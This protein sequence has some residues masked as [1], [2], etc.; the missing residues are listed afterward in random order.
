MKPNEIVSAGGNVFTYM[1]AANQ[2]NEI[3]QM[4]EFILAITTS[5]L[6]IGYR[7]Y[8]WIKD[9]KADGKITKDELEELDNIMEDGKETLEEII[10]KKDEET[11]GKGKDE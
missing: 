9:S 11:S 2:V 4:I 8:R 6:L 10:N 1:L 5:L 3:L 7:I